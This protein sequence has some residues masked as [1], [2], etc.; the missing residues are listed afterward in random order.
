[1]GKKYIFIKNLF[2]WPD[3]KTNNHKYLEFSP[4]VYKNIFHT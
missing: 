3:R 4:N 2:F 1:M